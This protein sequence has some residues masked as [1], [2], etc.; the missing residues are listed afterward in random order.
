MPTHLGLG[1]DI[2]LVLQQKLHQ[3]DVSIMTGHVEWSITHLE[4]ETGLWVARHH[5]SHA[6]AESLQ[7]Q[8]LKGGEE[9][10]GKVRA[11][12]DIAQT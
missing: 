5:R 6:Q 8:L 3:L 7:K 12:T 11:A 4:G 1:I 2:C 9:A 10:E